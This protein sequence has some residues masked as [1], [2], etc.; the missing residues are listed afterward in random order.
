[1]KA[2]FGS[3]GLAAGTML[4]MIGGFA[5]PAIAAPPAAAAPAGPVAAAAAVANGSWTVYH[6]DAAH[7]GYDSTQPQA[8]TASAGWVSPALDGQ[9][10][11]EP[12]VYNGLVY[13]GTLNNT[14]YALNQATGA[15]V[16]SRHLGTPQISGWQCGN[17]NP[18]GILGTGVIDVNHGTV[19]FV[20]FLARYLSYYLYALN[21]GT[22]AIVHTTLIKPT[23]F[24]WTIEQQRGALALSTDGTHV[25]VPFGGR[26][27]DCGLY[28]GYVEGAPTAG[29]A[30][31][32]HYRTPST[33]EGIWAAGGVV[34]DNATGHVFFAT[35]NAMPTCSG[36]V[37]SD[38]VIRTAANLGSATFFQPSD[39]SANWCA[40]DLDLGSA[41]PVVIGKNLM[42][43]SGKYGSGFLLNPNNLGGRGGQLFRADVCHGIHSDATFGSFAYQSPYLFLECDGGGLVRL[44]VNTST[45][46]FSQC[47]SSCASPS[48]TVGGSMTFGPPIVAGGVVWVIDINGTGLY[49]YSVETGAQVFHSASFGVRHFVTP[50]EAG[51]QVFVPSNTVVRSFNMV[52]GCKGVTVTPS[53]SSPQEVG[54]AV[55][56]VANATGCPNA[57]P[58]YEFWIRYPG[59][60]LWQIAKPWSTTA[61]FNWATG[62]LQAGQYRFSVWVKDSASANS[63]DAFDANTFYDLTYTPC[64]SVGV[65]ASP[66]SPEMAGV[67]VTVN[68][69]TSRCPNPSYEFW[70][71]PPGASSWGTPAQAYST[72]NSYS[73]STTGLTAGTYRFSVWARDATSNFSYDAFNANFFFT[74]TA[75]CPSV[76]VSAS[77]PG[78]ASVGT[79]PVVITATAAGCLNPSPLYQFWIRRPGSTTWQIAQPYSTDNTFDWDTRTGYATGTYYFSVW[80]RDSSSAGTFSNSLGRYDAFNSSLAYGLS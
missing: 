58:S 64:T 66:P 5:A 31:N 32:E 23:G 24:D 4:A 11:T 80:V 57:T 76:A 26:A 43:M 10:Y 30:V 79:N 74:V 40:P 72:S 47:A 68:A 38:S 52:F 54:T 6:H 45:N 9:V 13:V 65:S 60:S 12:L 25:Y 71:L 37:T 39:W 55:D 73:W 14:A 42:F 20:A 8:I 27:G 16:W 21:L 22:G 28:H 61:T 29:G 62:T 53:P 33:G 36:A 48:W 1:V 17:V 15:V 50:S 51:G 2:R 67:A 63:Y 3:L 70:I 18:T 77:P 78:S 19:Y 41:S 59:S 35:G 56:I 75:G 46:T 69:T 49:G 7:T 44:R 34:V